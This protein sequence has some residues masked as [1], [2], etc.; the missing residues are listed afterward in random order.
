MTPRPR[1]TRPNELTAYKKRYD[2]GDILPPRF[3]CGVIVRTTSRAF[4]ILLL[5]GLLAVASAAAEPPVP[6]T[7]AERPRPVGPVAWA[8]ELIRRWHASLQPP[9][10]TD[11]DQPRRLSPFVSSVLHPEPLPDPPKKNEL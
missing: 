5:A 8:I 4:R 2:S 11:T 1:A 9:V 10:E 3:C 6:A 7:V